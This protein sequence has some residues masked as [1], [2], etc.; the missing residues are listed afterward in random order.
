MQGAVTRESHLGREKNG[1]FYDYSCP[2]VNEAIVWVDVTSNENDPFESQLSLNGLLSFTV[3][4]C[5]Q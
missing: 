2:L 4:H 5:A 1:Y 3:T